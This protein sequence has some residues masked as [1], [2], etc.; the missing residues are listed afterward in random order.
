MHGDI[1]ILV[2]EFK[3]LNGSL[4]ENWKQTK[5]NCDTLQKHNADLVRHGVYW[6]ALF[7]VIP[8]SGTV[9][10]IIWGVSRLIRR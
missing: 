4:K 10:G 6:K 3:A 9:L 1:K 7:A 5:I 8:V 2:T